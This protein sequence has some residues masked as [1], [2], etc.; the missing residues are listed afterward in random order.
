MAS[1][2]TDLPEPDSPTSP[3]TWPWLDREAQLMHDRLAAKLNRQ[4]VDGEQWLA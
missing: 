3:S 1:D 4:P 2:V